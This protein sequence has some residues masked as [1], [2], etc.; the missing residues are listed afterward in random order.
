MLGHLVSNS[1]ATPAQPVPNA[2]Q[3]RGHQQRGWFSR[4]IAQLLHRR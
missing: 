4:M 3:R 2:A 1:L